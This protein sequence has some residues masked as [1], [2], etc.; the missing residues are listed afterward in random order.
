MVPGGTEAPSARIPVGAD[1][2]VRRGPRIGLATLIGVLCTV[3]LWRLLDDPRTGLAGAATAS[4]SSGYAGIEWSGLAILA[5][6]ALLAAR[7]L[8]PRTLERPIL[9]VARLLERPATLLFAATAAL[10]AFAAS[11]AFGH[12]VLAGQ[13]NLVDAMSQLLHARFLAAGSPAGPGNE[14]GEFW[15]PQQSLFTANGWVSQYPPGHVALLALGM[16]VG[17]VWAVGP[18]MLAVTAFFTTLAAERLLP[19]RRAIARLGALMVAV[20]PF[21]IAHAGA[22]MS[23]TTAAA[24]GTIAVWSATRFAMGGA[25][26]GLAAGAALGAMF[27]TRPLSALT[28]AAVITV[29]LTIPADRHAPRAARTG[30]VRGLAIVGGAIPFGLLVAAYNLHFFGSATTFGY[31]AALGPAG[32]LGFGLDP[33]GN[34]YS[35]MQAM[36]Y[37]SA[38]LSALSLF[39]LETPVPLVVFIA[40]WLAMTPRLEPGERLIAGWALA[41]LAAQLLY[42]HHGLFMGP[43]MLN[44][45]APAW[46]LLAA[47]AVPWLVSRLPDRVP[48]LGP[49]SPR[50]FGAT[51]AGCA[52]VAALALAP[53]RLSSYTQRPTAPAAGLSAS[54]P[55]LVFVHGGWTSRLWAK[56]AASGMR[57]DSIESALRQNPTCAVQMWADAGPSGGRVPTLSFERRATDLPQAVE[58]SAGNRIRV[59]SGEK[60]TGECARQAGADR[61]GTIDVTPLLW[62]GSVPGA[63]TGGVVFA[64]DM[65]PAANARL[66]EASPGR[67]PWLLGQRSEDAPPELIVYTEA[68]RVLWG[69]P[70]GT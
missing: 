18:A 37:T 52:C 34:A 25:G 54:P 35:G 3:P 27:A 51:M 42:W 10:I 61:F 16:K 9:A 60:L 36:A 63:G 43:R 47:I 22:Y 15:I 70:E 49:Y 14:F 33:W 44:E 6:P 23:H 57:L 31:G 13:P 4:M 45:A 20:S 53:L 62:L 28:L 19:G 38:E 32:G 68:M 30:V 56:L 65:G 39:L 11:A 40:A 21:L 29:W 64:R 69:A 59:V 8:H 24:F 67:T 48:R 55:A 41:P 7:A 5:I 1:S 66:I 58:I 17:L 46:C 50:S 26:W 12:F 2:A